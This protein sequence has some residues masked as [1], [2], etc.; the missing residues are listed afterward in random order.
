VVSRTGL[1][2]ASVAF[3]DLDTGAR[4]L[5]VQV[6]TIGRLAISNSFR[7]L[8]TGIASLSTISSGVGS[9]PRSTAG[10]R[11]LQITN[12]KVASGA[13]TA[14]W[15]VGSL[16]SSALHSCSRPHEQLVLEDV[17]QPCQRVAHGRLAQAD[18]VRGAGHMQLL[19]ERI[20][21]NEQ[22]EIDRSKVH[23]EPPWSSD[24]HSQ[25]QCY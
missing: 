22:V 6:S 16:S 2:V 7:T 18:A 20:Q 17:A 21:C 12:T 5:A 19:H 10:N 3:P 8:S 24:K 9:R 13:H 25:R 1:A 15:R 4:Q 11:M 14:G 23:G